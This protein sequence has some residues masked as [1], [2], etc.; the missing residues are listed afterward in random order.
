VAGD[1]FV[2]ALAPGPA[3]AAASAGE[4]LERAVEAIGVVRRGPA[5]DLVVTASV[6]RISV[7]SS[8][9]VEA[10]LGRADGAMYVRKR[11][12]KLEVAATGASGQA[13]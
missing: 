5:G 2:V 1:E 11:A 4:D 9:P 12:R 13:Y 6:G 8:E 3:P 10:V 7:A